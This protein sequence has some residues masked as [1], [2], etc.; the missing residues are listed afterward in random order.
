[1][2]L[3]QHAS[4]NMIRKQ[5]KS[6]MYFKTCIL[7]NL[8]CLF[9]TMH[10]LCED[11]RGATFSTP[12]VSFYCALPAHSP[13]S[14]IC[15]SSSVRLT[16]VWCLLSVLF[17]MH[18]SAQL[19]ES[20]EL[21]ADGALW[22]GEALSLHSAHSPYNLSSFSFSV[23]SPKTTEGT[24]DHHPLCHHLPLCRRMSAGSALGFLSGELAAAV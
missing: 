7:K 16:A 15:S 13:V 9:I 11:K 14:F 10:F 23:F 24:L 20:P 17:Y 12:P 1:M 22:V 6:K 21:T 5:Q 4:K 3:R 19:N 18:M 8:S 2:N